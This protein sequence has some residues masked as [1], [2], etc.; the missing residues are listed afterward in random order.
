MELVTN[1]MEF[2][3]DYLPGGIWVPVRLWASPC[4]LSSFSFRRGVWC[5]FGPSR[6]P[7][8]V[9]L[10][11]QL[12]Q[13]DNITHTLLFL[14]DSSG[15]RRVS[16]SRSP[17]FVYI[18]RLY[19]PSARKELRPRR[20]WV[21]MVPSSESTNPRHLRTI[22][23]ARN[24]NQKKKFYNGCPGPPR[25]SSG[26][27]D[28]RLLDP[29]DN[30]Y[31]SYTLFFTLTCQKSRPGSFGIM[32]GKKRGCL[33]NWGPRRTK[34]PIK[35]NTTSILIPSFDYHHQTTG[36]RRVSRFFNQYPNQCGDCFQTNLM[37]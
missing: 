3:N 1:G 4:P 19:I 34:M 31:R 23:T 13:R 20:S 29:A 15:S 10:L 14:Q 22:T 18:E 21:P 7:L 11:P 9:G 33:S 28:S 36:L 12:Q 6:I 30:I 2:Y 35:Q 32:D 25:A 37:T 16:S 27:R 8:V 5:P 26:I 24:N 17:R